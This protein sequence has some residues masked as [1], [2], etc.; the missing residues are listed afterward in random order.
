MSLET[1]I[2]VARGE[3]PADLW[4]KN[5]RLVNVLSGEIHPADVAIYD[6]HVVGFGSYEQARDVVDLGGKFLC[7]GFMDAHVHLESSMVQPAEFARAVL[8]HG[9]T[10]VV[11]DP[12]EI[13]N[14]LGL[15][16]VHYILNASEG[17]PLSIYVMAPSCVPA[18]HMESAGA[19]LTASDI[20]EL[21]THERVIGLAEMMNFPGVL[22]RVPDVLPAYRAWT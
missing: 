16:G 3:Q 5:A 6:G 18:T 20:Q 9:T 10:A 4:L 19:H 15:A 2:A 11:C 12:H 22:Y 17:L 7:P 13:A 8:P 21:W 14:V 1:M